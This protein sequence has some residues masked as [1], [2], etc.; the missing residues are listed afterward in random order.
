MG[1]NVAKYLGLDTTLTQ[2][3]LCELWFDRVFERYENNLGGMNV[4]IDKLSNKLIGQ[5]GL[6]VQT[7]DAQ[8]RLEVGYSILSQFRNKG[9]A[10]EAAQKCRNYAFKN[11]F[12]QSLISIVH[13]DNKASEKVALNNGMYLEKTIDSFKGNPVNIFQINKRSWKNDLIF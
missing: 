5:C 3:Q 7:V 13:V 10:T 11:N 9:Y 6:L 1:D 2:E 4:L 12:T 8:Q